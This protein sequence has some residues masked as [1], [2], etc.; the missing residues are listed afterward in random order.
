[1]WF[2]DTW[3]LEVKPKDFCLKQFQLL[4]ETLLLLDT[5]WEGIEKS[6][7][8]FNAVSNFLSVV[9]TSTL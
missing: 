6:R 5:Y 2:K 7:P 1:M 8:V 3:S 9:S 4:K